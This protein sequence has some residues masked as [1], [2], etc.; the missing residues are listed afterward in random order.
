MTPLR[1]SAWRYTLLLTC[2]TFLLVPFS[3]ARTAQENRRDFQKLDT[4][5]LERIAKLGEEWQSVDEGHLQRLLIPRAGEL[6]LLM[7]VSSLD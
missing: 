2:L 5:S 6:L 3:A 1:T 4:G 7:S